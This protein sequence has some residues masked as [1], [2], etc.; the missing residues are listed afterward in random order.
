MTAGS[1]TSRLD[2]DASTKSV[3]GPRRQMVAPAVFRLCLLGLCLVLAQTANVGHVLPWL[4][5]L[6]LLAGVSFRHEEMASSHVVL[7]AEVALTC[8][9]VALTGG[10]TSP[11]LAYLPA[12]VLAAGLRYGQLYAVVYGGQIAAMLILG[13]TLIGPADGSWQTF[14][15]AAAQWVVLSVAVGVLADRIRK[16]PNQGKAEIDASYEEAL[17]LLGQLRNVT[18]RL[19]GSLDPVFVAEAMLESCAQLANFQTAAVL[20]HTGDERLAPLATRGM[21]RVPWRHPLTA[22]GPLR[23]AWLDAVPVL[24]VRLPDAV[25][26]RAGSTL[27]VLPVTVADQMI[28]LVV[29]ESRNLGAFPPAVMSALGDTVL[30]QALRLSTAV[31]FDEFRTYAS[32]EE[33]E[34][35]AREMHDGVGQDLAAIGFELDELRHHL[36][37]HDVAIAHVGDVRQHVTDMVRDIRLSITE[38]RSGELLSRGLGAAL[39][40]HVRAAGAGGGFI[41]HLSLDESTF[42]LPADT[43]AELLRI[44]QELTSAARR[45]FSAEN[46]WVALR[47]DPPAAVLLLEHD[48]VDLQDFPENADLLKARVARVGGQ[49]EIGAPSSSRTYVEITLGGGGHE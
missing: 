16:F 15:S 32:M 13:R 43:E 4:A 5:A 36:W 40:S 2:P 1:V 12:P 35:L 38:L 21:Q 19:P 49:L 33:R 44:T 46:V 26:R 8:T 3:R 47:V 20:V 27:V 28:G 34:R 10:A 39:T 17:L 7:F 45:R 9:A 6:L 25:G 18:R 22:P 42:R 31:V 11:L 48:G 41:V 14:S 29:L 23:T 24:D 37:G 30:R